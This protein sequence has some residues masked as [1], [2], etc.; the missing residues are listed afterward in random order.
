MHIWLRK[1]IHRTPTAD[2]WVG[3]NVSESY[4]K[5]INSWKGGRMLKGGV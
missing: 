1:V 4:K 5:I 3:E 2:T